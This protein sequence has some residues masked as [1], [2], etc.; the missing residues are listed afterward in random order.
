MMFIFSHFNR[1][2]AVFTLLTLCMGMW[3]QEGNPEIYR[4]RRAMTIMK[5]GNGAILIPGTVRTPYGQG[6]TGRL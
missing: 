3:A 1:P 6:D 5:T 4:A 2:V